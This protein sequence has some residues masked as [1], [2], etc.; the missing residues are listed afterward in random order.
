MKWLDM[1]PVW[2]ICF[3]FLAWGQAR[4]C[5]FNLSLAHPITWCL[6]GML[7]GAGMVLTL[8][9]VV[10]FRR[11]RTT[12]IPHKMPRNLVR[13]GIFSWTRNPIYLAD[14]LILTGLCLWWDAVVGLILVPI[15]VWVLKRRFI[16]P[17]EDRMHRAFGAEFAFYAQKTR[18]WV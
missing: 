17:E 9:A 7:I 12:I 6:A 14:V 16:L 5:T 13:S 3:A 4:A 8:L 11:N 10:E 1:P 18:R 2:L 15:L